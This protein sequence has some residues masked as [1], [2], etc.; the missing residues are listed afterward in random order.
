MR[1]VS[2]ILLPCVS[3]GRSVVTFQDRKLTELI[4]AGADARAQLARSANVPD[5]AL[6]D[7]AVR[8]FIIHQLDRSFDY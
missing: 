6:V 4:A 8:P 1:R 3:D 2:Y 7:E 5:Q